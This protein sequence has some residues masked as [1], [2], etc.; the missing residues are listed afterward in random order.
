MNKELVD[1]IRFNETFYTTFSDSIDLLSEK[2]IKR[3]EADLAEFKAR[4]IAANESPVPTC[5]DWVML[6]NS[7]FERITVHTERSVQ[8]GG[9][10]NGSYYLLGNGGC[11]YSGLCGNSIPINSL[12]RSDMFRDGLCWLFSGGY[13]GPGLMVSKKMPF[14]VWFQK[15]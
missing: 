14:R 5:G 10:E 7:T 4:Q 13:S 12:S 3:A 9:T 8:I 6:N 1:F 11:L 2:V 15:H